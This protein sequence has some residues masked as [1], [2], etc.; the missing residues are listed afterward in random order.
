MKTGFKDPI[1]P[2]DKKKNEKYPWDYTAP[3]YDERSSGYINAGSNY[4]KCHRQPVG[5]EGTPHSRV[6][7]L[8]F[9]RP[10]LMKVEDIS[11]S[12]IKPEFYE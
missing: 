8:P 7:T 9:G 11:P 3:H 4:G 6:P 12:Q 2:N 1:A 5:R 10:N